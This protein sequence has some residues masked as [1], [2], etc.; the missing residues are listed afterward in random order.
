V[1]AVERELQARKAREAEQKRQAAANNAEAWWAAIDQGIEE[2]FKYCFSGHGD[3]KRGLYAGAI[4]GGA[5]A[6]AAARRVQACAR[7]GAALV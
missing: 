4:G 1:L 7:R 3:G 5:H 6:R 2:W